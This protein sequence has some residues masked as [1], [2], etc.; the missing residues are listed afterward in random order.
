MKRINWPLL[1]GGIILVGILILMVFPD[2]IATKSPYTLQHMRFSTQDNQL[3][4]ESAPYPPSKD[5]IFGSDD[6]GRDIFSYIVYGTKLT[7][8][9]GIFM[10]L[11]QFLLQSLWRLWEVLAIR[12]LNR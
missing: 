6:L 12:V 10:S 11:G 3:M 4:V 5:Y 7:I 1:L 2:K 8:L 9:L